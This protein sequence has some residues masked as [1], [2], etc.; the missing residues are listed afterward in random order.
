MVS[1]TTREAAVPPRVRFGPDTLLVRLGRYAVDLAVYLDE[2][3]AS[4]EN[5]IGGSSENSEMRRAL[6]LCYGAESCH[7]S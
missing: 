4:C 1:G 2:P 7:F 5:S 6:V 3:S